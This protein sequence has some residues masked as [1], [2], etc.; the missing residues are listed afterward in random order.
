[1]FQTIFYK[2]IKRY[3]HKGQRSKVETGKKKKKKKKKKLLIYNQ[4]TKTF[5]FHEVV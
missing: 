5:I 1:M 4:H 3:D 2:N